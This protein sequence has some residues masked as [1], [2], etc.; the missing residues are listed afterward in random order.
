MIIFSIAKSLILVT[1]V[2]LLIRIKS[3]FS[4]KISWVQNQIKIL[5]NRHTLLLNYLLAF[6]TEK[7]KK[8]RCHTQESHQQL[9]LD[10]AEKFQ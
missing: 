2:V 6:Q 5:F 9:M 1:I 3:P 7:K 8:T 10:M 4:T